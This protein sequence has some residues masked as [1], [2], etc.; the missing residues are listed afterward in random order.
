MRA[1]LTASVRRTIDRIGVP[2]RGDTIVVALSGGPDS[3]ALLD[4]LTA[5]A[6]SR[7]WRV[8]AAHLDHGLRPGSAED[9]AFCR[10]LCGRLGVPLRAGAADVRARLGRDHGGLEEAG[11]LERYAFLRAVKREEGASVVAVAHTRDDQAETLLL[12]L[13]RGSGRRG[14]A[15]MRE[16]SGDIVR[17]LLGASRG[18]VLAHLRER[19]LSWL[20]DPTNQDLKLVRNRVRH[21]LIPYLEARFNPNVRET[22]ARSARLLGDDADAVAPLA[23]ALW[24]QA[25]SAPSG[26]VALSRAALKGAPLGL[27]RAVVRR[28]IEESGGLRSVTLGHVDRVLEIARSA[29][30]AARRLP[31]PGGRTAVFGAREVR[32]ARA[33]RPAS[34]PAA[35]G[36]AVGAA[37]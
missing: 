14:L 25:A 17:P 4:A 13:L 32:F 34:A 31:L 35:A 9:A 6:P 12:R 30:G 20:E 2:A 37:R 29:S 26:E 10:E 24:L 15:S 33:P 1:S 28:A 36:T 16:R 19:G 23:E 22:L 7:G 8:V 3:V 18:Q 27:A 21:E 11:R 5:L